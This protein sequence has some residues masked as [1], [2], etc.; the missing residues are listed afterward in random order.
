MTT[1]SVTGKSDLIVQVNAADPTVG[2]HF[3]QGKST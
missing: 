3:R 2:T 1:H